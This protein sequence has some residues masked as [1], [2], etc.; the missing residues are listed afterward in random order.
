MLLYFTVSLLAQLLLRRK[1]AEKGGV[2]L[3]NKNCENCGKEI[4]EQRL[5]ACPEAKTCLKCN[6]K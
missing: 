2:A 4:G 3:E 6:E 1:P 5:K